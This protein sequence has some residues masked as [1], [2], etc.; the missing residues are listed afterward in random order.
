M[1]DQKN[2]IPCCKRKWLRFL[3]SRFEILGHPVYQIR[4][5]NSSKHRFSLLGV[6][7]IFVS[8]N[9][10]VGLSDYYRCRYLN[11][12]SYTQKNLLISKLFFST[13]RFKETHKV[14][15]ELSFTR[16]ICNYAQNDCIQEASI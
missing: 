15:L 9:E 12:L 1:P 6:N 7:E 13:K 3:K 16:L 4:P 14:S 11:F 2:L 10:I 8:G 5:Q